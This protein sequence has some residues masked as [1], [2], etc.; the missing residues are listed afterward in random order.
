MSQIFFV[1]IGKLM[2]FSKCRRYIYPITSKI[3]IITT[4]F[5]SNIFLLQ[6]V[7]MLNFPNSNEI[8]EQ[9]FFILF[10]VIFLMNC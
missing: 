5:G 2:S 3:A 6:L 9:F 4:N 8:V 1:G 7:I 10:V